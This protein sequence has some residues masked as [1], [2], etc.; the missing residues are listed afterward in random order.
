MAKYNLM[1]VIRRLTVAVGMM[2]ACLPAIAAGP[3]TV[4]MAN[5]KMTAY[6]PAGELANGQAVVI[7]PGGGYTHL[8]TGH[9]GYQWAP[10]FNDLGYA[11][12]VLEYSFPKGD[13][14]LPMRDVEECFKVVADSASVWN[15]SADKIGIMGS[16]AGGHLASTM[17][18]HSTEM[19]RPAFQI[20]FY[21]V[22]SLEKGVTHNG[23]ADGFLGQ[24]ASDA[25]RHEWSNQYNVTAKTPPAFIVLSGDDTVVPPANSIMYYN[26][27]NAAGV[28]ASLHIYPAG[29]HGWGYKAG[30]GA[31]PDREP[32]LRELRHWLTERQNK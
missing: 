16:S 15:I 11:A 21:P 2:A 30:P 31:L 14:T 12:I 18:T 20:L 29:G 7:C 25:L 32:M 19:C 6:L 10:F 1:K 4:E 28:P 17:A 5:P 13:R 24:N 3:R 23:T 26:A 8:A 22:I 9:E 27:L